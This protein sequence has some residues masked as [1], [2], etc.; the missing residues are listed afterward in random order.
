MQVRL[1]FNNKELTKMWRKL[2]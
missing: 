2:T 1:T